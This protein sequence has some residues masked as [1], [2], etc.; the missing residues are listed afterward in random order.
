MAGNAEKAKRAL[1][2]VHQAQQEEGTVNKQKPFLALKCTELPKAEKWRDRSLERSLKK[3]VAYI[4]NAGLV[5]E[6]GCPDYG[7]NELSLQLEDPPGI[8]A[9]PKDRWP[10]EH[11][12]GTQGGQPESGHLLL[13]SPPSYLSYLFLPGMLL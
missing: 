7:K 5:K 2:R 4:Q 12:R 13:L 11:T 6:W 9:S 1:P 8:L 10:H 3:K